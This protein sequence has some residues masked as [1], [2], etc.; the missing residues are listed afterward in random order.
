MK[1]GSFFSAVGSYQEEEFAVVINSDR[2]VVDKLEH[3]LH[4]K[5]PVIALMIQQGLIKAEEIIE[6]GRIISGEIPG[7]ATDEERIFSR[8]SEWRSKIYVSRLKFIAWLW[9]RALA[10]NWGCLEGVFEIGEYQF[11]QQAR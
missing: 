1:A 10:P 7:R 4:R 3:V 2:V 5:T 8:Q 9:K 6:L 11:N